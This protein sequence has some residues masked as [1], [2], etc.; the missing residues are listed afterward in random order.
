MNNFAK[1][2]NP[3]SSSSTSNNPF[4]RGGGKESDDRNFQKFY[5]TLAKDPYGLEGTGANTQVVST[6]LAA[7]TWDRMFAAP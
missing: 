7:P 1:S 3:F 5:E 2:N 4:A 6:T